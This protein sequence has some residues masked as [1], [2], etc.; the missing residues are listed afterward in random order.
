MTDDRE[1]RLLVTCHYVYFE[2]NSIKNFVVTEKEY[3]SLRYSGQ[4]VFLLVLSLFDTWKQ[5]SQYI[6]RGTVAI[7]QFLSMCMW[8]CLPP[9]TPVREWACDI[10]PA[11]KKHPV[12]SEWLRDGHVT[13]LE[14]IGNT[15][16]LVR[17]LVGETPH[18]QLHLN[19][20]GFHVELADR[21]V[22]TMWSLKMKNHKRIKPRNQGKLNLEDI[23]WALATTWGPKCSSN[24]RLVN[25]TS[26]KFPCVV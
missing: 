1:F 23:G 25:S 24:L 8:S 19:L 18:F 12:P 9:W 20:G 10:D 26:Q 13:Q 7:L 2:L 3:S 14:T 22:S 21:H 6:S 4:Q 16:T 11:R 17:T 15:E 5:V